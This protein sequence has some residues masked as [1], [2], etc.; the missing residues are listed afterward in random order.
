MESKGHIIVGIVSLAVLYYLNSVYKWIAMP[1][2][3]YPLVAVGIIY[4]MM[5]DIDQPG[6]IIN[7]YFTFA[8]V[9]VIILAFLY[10]I[11]RDYGI[12]AAVVLGLL[13]VFNHRTFVHSLVGGAIIAAP[14]LYAGTLYFIVGLAA[15]LSHIMI[16]GEFSIAFEHDWW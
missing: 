9:G 6:S 16:E 10:P 11:Y 13:R 5:P 7:R 3:I 14:L 8:M 12:I 1:E 15:F 4:S 2:N